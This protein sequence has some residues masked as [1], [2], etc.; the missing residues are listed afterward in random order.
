MGFVRC[1]GP[2]YSVGTRRKTYLAFKKVRER[3]ESFIAGIL[4]SDLL[5]KCRFYIN[6]LLHSKERIN[7]LLI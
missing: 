4:K 1:L 7:S 3:T 6:V 2:I 5:T